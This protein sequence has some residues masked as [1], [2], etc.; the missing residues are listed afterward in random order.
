M[1]YSMTHL[2]RYFDVS[3]S[4]AKRICKQIRESPRYSYQQDY[5]RVKGMWRYTKEA[6]TDERGSNEGN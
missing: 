4:T 3:E 5:T 2:K 6:F 1:F